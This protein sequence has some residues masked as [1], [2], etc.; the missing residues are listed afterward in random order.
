MNIHGG[1][2]RRGLNMPTNSTNNPI[3]SIARLNYSAGIRVV[4]SRC[5]SRK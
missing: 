2:N 4:L 3:S 5:V 1:L